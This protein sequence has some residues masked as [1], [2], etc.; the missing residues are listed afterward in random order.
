[1]PKGFYALIL[2]Q[3]M[4]ALADN[5]LLLLVIALLQLQGYPAFWIPLLKLFFTVSYVLFGPWVGALAD[6]WSKHHLLQ[7]A[8]A[9]KLFACLGL[10]AGIHPLV[11]FASRAWVRLCIRL[12]NMA[13]SP[14][15]WTQ[16]NCSKPMVG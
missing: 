16:T 14:R 11:A 15:W 10:L 3:W 13:G 5:A 7:Q 6:T 4:S 12:P 1:M 8:N 2:C 9:L